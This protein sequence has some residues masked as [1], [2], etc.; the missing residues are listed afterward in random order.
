MT[1]SHWDLYSQD[2]TYAMLQ[3]AEYKANEKKSMVQVYR[4][5]TAAAQD[6]L[7]EARK[8]LKQAES[9]IVKLKT[10]IKDFSNGKDSAT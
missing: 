7:T 3:K 2:E 1:N 6:N 8:Y 5:A 4:G 9:T 10:E